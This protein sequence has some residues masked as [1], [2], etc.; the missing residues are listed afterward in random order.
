MNTANLALQQ[1]TTTTNCAFIWYVPNIPSMQQMIWTVLAMIGA[2]I[3]P[4]KS[5]TCLSSV[6]SWKRIIQ[7]IFQKNCVIIMHQYI[8]SLY[9]C[10]KS[11]FEDSDAY[12]RQWCNEFKHKYSPESNVM[13]QIWSFL[14]L[15][16]YSFSYR[17][18]YYLLLD[19]ITVAVKE[20]FYCLKPIGCQCGNHKSI[21]NYYYYIFWYNN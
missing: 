19:L 18:W 17:Q 9:T 20:Q 4:R 21:Y 11:S 1:L 10:Y 15:F 5:N 8:N 3:Y 14:A 2:H 16:F 13:I 12:Y 7:K 6:L